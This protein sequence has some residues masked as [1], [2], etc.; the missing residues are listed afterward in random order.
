MTDGKLKAANLIN[1]IV[2]IDFVCGMMVLK[3]IM[4]KTKLLAD[5]LQKEYVGIAGSLTAIELALA[6]LSIVQSAEKEIYDKIDAAMQVARN[7][8]ADPIADFARLRRIRKPS[9]RLDDQPEST[10][11]KLNNIHTFY[12]T[13]VFKF[14]DQI[15]TTLTEKRNSLRSTF[16]PFLRALNPIIP[17]EM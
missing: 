12:R 10:A 15:C 17:S 9:K 6:S 13:E 14:L 16:F 1:A 2:N 8:G 7:L 5:F 3:N 4:Y 11:P